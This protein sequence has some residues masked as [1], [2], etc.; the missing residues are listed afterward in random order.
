M[1]WGSAAYSYD[2]LDRLTLEK[3]G[4]KV[5]EAFTYDATGNRLSK[6]V[7]TKTTANTYP[8][9]SHRLSAAGNTNRSY[10]A[11]G[12]TATVGSGNAMQTF[13]Y[14]D[15]NRLRDYKL[16]T[17]LKS[18]YRYNGKGEQVLR[19]DSTTPANSRQYVYDEAG[20][21]L[22]EYTTAGVRIQEY[23][24]LDDTLV[25][26]LSDHDGS[27]YQYVETDHLGTPRAVIHPTR[28]TIVWRW[29][30]NDT[31]FGDHTPLG[32]PDG[33]AITYT[34]NLRYPGQRADPITGL[35]YNYFRDYDPAT[36]RYGYSA[37]VKPPFRTMGSQWRVPG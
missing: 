22:G 19:I 37:H 31:T 32:D 21:L 35:N 30:V 1:N 3:N 13:V 29:N 2:G 10:D 23:V 36:G 24:W 34:L 33:N 20:H 9:D 27:T 7:G 8:V 4:T 26:I 25:G 12:N 5:V 17:T 18:S 14:D 28:N 16:G 15:R 6:T 11:N